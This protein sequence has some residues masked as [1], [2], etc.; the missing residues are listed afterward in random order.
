[1]TGVEARL[2]FLAWIAAERGASPHT[3]EAYGRDTAEFLGFLGG[4][5]GEEPDM[6]ALGALRPADLRAFLAARA[7]EGD[8]AA[9][10]ARKLAAVRGFLRFLIRRHGLPPLALAGLRGP[11]P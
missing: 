2:A 10:R 7:A 5:L 9:T 4:H 8:G 1:M 6:A 11:R 3:I